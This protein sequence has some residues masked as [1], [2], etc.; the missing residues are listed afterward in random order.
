METKIAHGR[1]LSLKEQSLKKEGILLIPSLIILAICSIIKDIF[2]VICIFIVVVIC[3][4]IF[5]FLQ[6]WEFISTKCKKVANKI[7]SKIKDIF[8]VI[9][10]SSILGIAAVIFY[11]L[12]TSLYIVGGIVHEVYLYEEYSAMYIER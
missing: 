3:L 4:I 8:A 1:N 2:V 5:Y 6:L 7:Y 10:I 12:Y 11:F 9:C